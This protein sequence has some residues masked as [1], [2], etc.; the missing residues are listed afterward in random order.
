MAEP[1]SQLTPA[2]TPPGSNPTP[3]P[4]PTAVPTA[5]APAAAASAQVP[6]AAAAENVEA[7]FI[8]GTQHAGV[9]SEHSF[10]A[11]LLSPSLMWFSCLDL[12]V[13]WFK[14]RPWGVILAAMPAA[15]VLTIAVALLGVQGTPQHRLSRWRAVYQRH[16]DQAMQAK[17]WDEAETACFALLSESPT[18]QPLRMSQARIA[19]GRERPE[20]AI[21]ILIGLAPEAGNGYKPARLLLVEKYLEAGQVERSERQLQLAFREDP[22]D[23]AIAFHY[24]RLLALTGRPDQ[25]VRVLELIATPNGMVSFQ[26]A[27]LYRATGQPAAAEAK[28]REA[29]NLLSKEYETSRSLDAVL[30]AVPAFRAVK[31]WDSATKLVDIAL[32]RSAFDERLALAS[33]DIQ[34]DQAA[35]FAAEGKF[36]EQWQLLEKVLA[37]TPNHEEALRQVTDLAFATGERAEQAQTVIRELL[38]SGQA[39]ASVHMVLGTRAAVEKNFA[40]A[41]LHFAQANA[42]NPR[43]ATILNNLSWVLARAE[44]PQLAEARL[45]AEEAVKLAPQ[46]AEIRD[47]RAVV[48]ILQGEYEAAI[49]DLEEAIRL[50]PGHRPY[51]ERLVKAYRA[52]GDEETAKQI[53]EGLERSELRDASGEKGP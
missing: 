53:E 27:Q 38:A 6:A 18:S 43:S 52:A 22:A 1:E 11:C 3:T 2:L 37:T 5:A 14:N 45:M 46:V 31:D 7:V 30:L 34:V 9:K 44:P 13:R 26:L 8:Y 48:M 39:P 35:Q 15:G 25:A 29:A 32:V 10:G 23:E 16:L 20:A 19:L 41:K 4:V 40:K 51:R 24:A 50:K 21:S 17:R 36:R 49:A 12:L 42:K 28:F 47:T 33:S